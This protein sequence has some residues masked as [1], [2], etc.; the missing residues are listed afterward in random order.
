MR[1][2]LPLLVLWGA[3]RACPQPTD[4]K[5]LFLAATASYAAGDYA[6]AE[7]QFL[8]CREALGDNAAADYNLALVY[9]R[10]ESPGRARLYLERCLRLAPRDREAREQL[11]LL[12]ARL[13]E[14]EPPP[15][16]WLHALWVGLR[17]SLTPDSALV[18]CA[19]A[20]VL[21]AAVLGLWLVWRRPRLRW[22]AVI[23]VLLALAT[24]PLAGAALREALGSPRAV[25]VADG[26]VV[27]G[28][29]GDDFG[30]IARLTEAQAVTL[31]ERPR[32]RLGPHLSVLVGR[33][34]R[35][36]WCEVRTSSGARGYVRRSQLE[37]VE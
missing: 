31:L 3:T 34:E 36:L 8:A 25:V 19:G 4:P 16:S 28:G 21:A 23:S 9:T 1:R 32:L 30:E 2:L 22:P 5:S 7:R 24:W 29:P 14:S 27:R 11:R 6:A 20:N 26:A 10:L 15:P 33:D 13:D 37:T 18:L 12:L 17:S 35:G